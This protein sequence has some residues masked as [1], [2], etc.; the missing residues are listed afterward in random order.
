MT[1]E[2]RPTLMKTIRLAP[3]NPQPPG[4]RQTQDAGFQSMYDQSR[5]KRKRCQMSLWTARKS[6]VEPKWYNNHVPRTIRSSAQSK[7][8][9]RPKSVRIMC[10]V[11]IFD[12]W[13]SK[14]Y[15][16]HFQIKNIICHG[17][18]AYWLG[19]GLTIQAKKKTKRDNCSIWC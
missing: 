11:P 18:D 6:E 13:H 15:V 3:G 4:E 9:G 2:S 19:N 14:G 10:N 17:K 8:V 16:P 1:R 5:M 12:H 7:S